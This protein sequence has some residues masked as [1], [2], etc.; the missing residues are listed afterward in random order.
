MSTQGLGGNERGVGV[1]FSG[2][3]FVSRGVNGMR[4][5]GEEGILRLRD[6]CGGNTDDCVEQRS[7]TQR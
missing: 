5:A 3:C 4:V 7:R 6:R 2:W 1:S